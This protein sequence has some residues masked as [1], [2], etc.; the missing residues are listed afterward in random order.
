MLQKHVVK[1]Y[2]YRNIN[3]VTD[4]RTERQIIIGKT[5]NIF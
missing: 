4:R 5:A 1:F 2:V 3:E